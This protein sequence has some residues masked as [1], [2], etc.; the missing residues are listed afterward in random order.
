[1]T[2]HFVG[3]FS[4]K[5]DAIPI[6]L[7]H[8]WPGSFL[9]FLPLLSLLKDKYSPEELPYHL[10]VPSLPGFTLSSGPPLDRDFTGQDTARVINQVMV[11]LGFEGGYVAQ[12][13]DIGSR[14]GRIMAVDYDACKGMSLWVLCFPQCEVKVRLTDLT[15]QRFIVSSYQYYQCDRRGWVHDLTWKNNPFQ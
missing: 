1:M 10:V 6:V 3:L 11:N 14:I 7:L 4:K 8:G 12:G 2:I 5:A 9:E 15:E 13:G